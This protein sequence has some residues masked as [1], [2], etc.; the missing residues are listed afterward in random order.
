MKNTYSAPEYKLILLT[1]QD[2]LT[3]SFEEPDPNSDPGVNDPF[4]PKA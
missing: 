3:Q 2:V 1:A 4:E